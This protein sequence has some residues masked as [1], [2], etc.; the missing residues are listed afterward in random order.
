MKIIDF[1]KGTLLVLEKTLPCERGNSE[2]K[3]FCSEKQVESKCSEQYPPSYKSDSLSN[4]N[5]ST[6]EG[7][8]LP[9]FL[10]KLAEIYQEVQVEVNDGTILVTQTEMN[11]LELLQTIESLEKKSKNITVA[12]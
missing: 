10:F 6:D 4:S 3:T 8:L 1:N 2:G 5:F 9:F 12:F 7:I 11:V